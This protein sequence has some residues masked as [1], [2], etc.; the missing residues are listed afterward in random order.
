MARIIGQLFERWTRAEGQSPTEQHRMRVID[1]EVALIFHGRASYPFQQV[2]LL[3]VLNIDFEIPC[4]SFAWLRVGRSVQCSR[5]AG[6]SGAN[7]TFG[8]THCTDAW[9]RGL[10]ARRNGGFACRNIINRA[11]PF[12]YG[13]TRGFGGI[14]V[15]FAIE[16]D[17][18][19][20]YRCISSKTGLR[21]RTP[22][23]S[24]HAVRELH[25]RLRISI[26]RKQRL[27]VKVDSRCKSLPLTSP[28]PRRPLRLTSP[29]RST[30]PSMAGYGK[31]RDDECSDRPSTSHNGSS[32]S[33]STTRQ[34][35]A[36]LS[37]A[38]AISGLVQVAVQLARDPSVA[39]H[40][41][42]H[43]LATPGSSLSSR[44]PP[45][46]D[47]GSSFVEL[48]SRTLHHVRSISPNHLAATFASLGIG[49][50]S[51]YARALAEDHTHTD[52]S[53]NQARATFS[54]HRSGATTPANHTR[55]G[56]PTDSNV[57]LKHH[58]QREVCSSTRTSTP[59]DGPRAIPSYACFP[60]RDIVQMTLP[61][62][63]TDSPFAPPSPVSSSLPT[64]IQNQPSG[65]VR[66]YAVFVG[67]SVG[68]TNSW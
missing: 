24:G 28:S 38:I 41:A 55:T 2:L 12:P 6:M 57:N 17:Q 20:T 62:G 35:A 47:A 29:R 22:R 23:F 33:N 3:D 9:T 8:S 58:I 18:S 52:S 5:C 30:V 50:P 67:T 51:V 42:N 40:V 36:G 32:N 48:D 46:S 54:T 63:P 37:L 15:P 34:R 45:P 4:T 21:L 25:I 39:N 27:E 44:S 65:R 68:V 16:I 10:G 64:S 66:W 60:L 49:D 7:R 13:G 59:S 26:R 14:A 53:N 61:V 11:D 19:P 56:S 43:G 1:V 31:R